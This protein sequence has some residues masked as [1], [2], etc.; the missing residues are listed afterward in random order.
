VASLQ[1]ELSVCFTDDSSSAYVRPRCRSPRHIHI[2]RLIV[3]ALATRPCADMSRRCCINQT[4]DTWLVFRPQEQLFVNISERCNDKREC[5]L[6]VNTR[7]HVVNSAAQQ[8]MSDYIIIGFDCVTNETSRPI[9][10][11]ICVNHSTLLAS[12]CSK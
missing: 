7:L 11:C 9:L 2:T 8:L 4:A 10:Y 12:T 5:T 3:G 1:C 6:L